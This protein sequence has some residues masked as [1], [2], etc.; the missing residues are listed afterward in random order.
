MVTRSL[1]RVK[2]PVVETMG[3]VDH[4]IRAQKS[5][6]GK[7]KGDVLLQERVEACAEERA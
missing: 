3:S 4:A 5:R 2:R 7:Q 6:A 1:I